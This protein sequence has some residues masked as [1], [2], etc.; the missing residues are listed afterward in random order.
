[1]RICYNKIK[2][3]LSVYVLA[4]LAFSTFLITTVSATESTTYVCTKDNDN[5]AKEGATSGTFFPGS[6]DIAEFTDD[7]YDDVS[8]N[9]TQYVY[10][11]YTS[12]TAQ[13]YQYHRFK[14]LIS[15]D[16]S[17]IV[18]IDITC[19]GHGGMSLSWEYRGHSIWIKQGG[20][21]VKK[22]S[23]T[24]NSDEILS[25]TYTSNFDDIITDGYLECIHRSDYKSQTIGD[26]SYIYT[27][28]VEVKVTY[29]PSAPNNPPDTTL[30]NIPNP[31]GS[32]DVQ[33]FTGTATDTDGTISSVVLTLKN[34]TDGSWWY[35]N[36]W[37]SAEVNPP[38][39]ASATDGSFNEASEEWIYNCILAGITWADGKQ[40]TITAIAQ[41]NDFYVDPS[42]ATDT[43]TYLSPSGN[44][45]PTAQYY[46]GAD[47]I[48]Y[49][50][51]EYSFTTRHK[52]IDGAD[53][54]EYTYA[55]IGS[56]KADIQF[57]CDPNSGSNPIVT[58]TYGSN[59]VSGVT[60]TRSS[61]TNGYDITWTYTI[62]WDWTHDDSSNIDYFA[63]ST[64]YNG[65]GDWSSSNQNADYEN[66][67]IVKS[68]SFTL[69]DPSYSEDGDT[70]LT[71]SEWFR[72]G[73]Q[74]K[75]TGVISYEG[76]LTTYPPS[77]ACDV[78]LYAN[79]LDTGKVDTSLDSNG[80][81]DT[82]FYTTPT[83]VGVDSDFDFEIQLENIISGAS[84]GTG[85]AYKSINSA[86][87]NE[88]PSAITNVQCRPDSFTDT[89]EYDDDSEIFFTWTNANDGSGSGIKTYY[90]EIADNTPDEDAGNDGQDTDLGPSGLVTYYVWACDNVGNYGPIS[91][92]TITIQL[93]DPSCLIDYSESKTTFS[94]GEALRILATFITVGID[95][96]ENSIKIE[97]I[98]QGN[99]DLVKTSMLKTDNTNWYY[100][101]TIPE[102]SDEDG[103]FTVKIYGM[104]KAGREINPNPATDIS[105]IID[106][107]G[108]VQKELIIIAPPSV[109]EGNFFELYVTSESIPVEN[110]KIIFNENIYYTKSDGSAEIIAPKVDSDTYYTI[111]AEKT[112]CISDSYQ[113]QVINII[114]IKYGYITGAVTDEDNNIIKNALV[115]IYPNGITSYKICDYT[116]SNGE[117]SIKAEE[118]DYLAIAS[119]EGYNSQ[120]KNIQITEDYELIVDFIFEEK[121]GQQTNIK[122][123][124]Q[125]LLFDYIVEDTAED[126]KA[127]AKI[128]VEE[129]EIL[130]LSE[131]LETNIEK[132]EKNSIV[133]KVNAPDGTSSKIIFVKVTTQTF[134]DI[135]EVDDIRVKYDGENIDRKPIDEILND[136]ET[137]PS[138][139]V[140]YSVE[141]EDDSFYIL[142]FVPSFSEHSINIYTV[143]PPVFGG[144]EA[145]FYNILFI[146][147]LSIF[148]IGVTIIRIKR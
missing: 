129:N 21:Y 80:E 88:A 43:F 45:P 14:F 68:V 98:T 86:R 138:W 73:S 127:G 15:E 18:R 56:S 147:L 31:A 96:N 5:I 117:Y 77:N 51:K 61:I 52:D 76:A 66:E 121:S 101:W 24:G 50:G 35:G 132:Q 104:D 130:I 84:E 133:L 57:R 63:C 143:I 2:F 79:S 20:T 131:G 90:A 118:N 97:I 67:I 146:G 109:I 145:I 38:L 47:Q 74:V 82:G 124:E 33:Q 108:E 7:E 54:I 106:N 23:G 94:E 40:Y 139:T 1:M 48:Q 136:D 75:A 8:V 4:L 44:S 36:S 29:N 59:Y 137:E 81:F 95:M 140:M 46:S 141:D 62:D 105:K 89:G 17:D 142:V 122:K 16:I 58:V 112:D 71:D 113:I 126:N 32:S 70:L 78:R 9:D 64:D 72:G 120:T 110:V 30:D 93:T 99:G 107:T 12:P 134:T 128:N 42:P 6:D 39:S 91:S 69:N 26:V 3:A 11:D 119:K 27:Y 87:D 114:E 10:D 115:C 22:D 53:E 123:S 49:A 116:D 65:K 60:A 41:D 37:T 102:G 25:T 13:K 100:D 55:A 111:T 83:T 103:Y 92:D 85:G 144:I 34:N 148:I 125:E 28:F 19:I 135:Q